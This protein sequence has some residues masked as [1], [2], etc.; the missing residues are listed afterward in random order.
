MG[1]VRANGES[2]TAELEI[3]FEHV[4]KAKW[5][6]EFFELRD[7]VTHSFEVLLRFNSVNVESVIVAFA[8]E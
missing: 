5:V 7:V 3:I 2:E 4:Q 1:F 8:E 6:D